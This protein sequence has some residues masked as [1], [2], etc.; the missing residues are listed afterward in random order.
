MHR[1]CLF[2]MGNLMSANNTWFGRELVIY[3]TILLIA[4]PNHAIGNALSVQLYFNVSVG[5]FT[6]FPVFKFI[7]VK[8]KLKHD[9]LLFVRPLDA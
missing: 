8:R 5:A 3:W 2:L 1:C 7:S 4:L 6:N 9:S